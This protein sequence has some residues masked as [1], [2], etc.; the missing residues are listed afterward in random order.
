MNRN[1]LGM[2]LSKLFGENYEWLIPKK[3]PLES[4]EQAEE[5]LQEGYTLINNHGYH[6]TLL[7]HSYQL[8]SNKKR[9]RDYK[10]SKY[11]LWQVLDTTKTTNDKTVICNYNSI[12]FRFDRLFRKL[13]S[14]WLWF[15]K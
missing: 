15:L 6:V 5:L 9:Q 7:N 1:K 4:Q 13:A 12:G 10:F 3:Y 11:Y 2:E 14:K 8:R